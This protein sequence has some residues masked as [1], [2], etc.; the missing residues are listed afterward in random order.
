VSFL[1]QRFLAKI[2]V[3]GVALFAAG[4]LGDVLSSGSIGPVWPA[5]GIALGAVLLCGYSVWPAVAAGAFLIGFLPP[6]PLPVGASVIYAAGT[7]LAALAGAFFLLRVAKF[8]CSLLRLRD[9]IELIVLGAFASST[10]SASIGAAVLYTH[11]GSWSGFGSAWL[12]YWLGDS[13]GVLLVTPLMLTFPGLFSIRDW[14][15]TAEVAALLL[16]LTAGGLVVFG[17]LP[18]IPGPLHVL[19]FAV[20]PL[21]MWAA[22]RLGISVTALSIFAVGTIATVETAL[23]SGPFTTN[24][25]LMNA[26]LLDVFFGVVSVTGLVLAAAVA[27]REH[28]ESQRE[29]LARKQ[30]AM[31]LRLRLATIVESSDDAVIGTDVNGTV[32]DWNKGAERLFG[33]AASEVIGKNISFIDSEEGLSILKKIVNREAV[34]NYE[35]VRR[36]KDGTRVDVSLTVSPIFDATGQIV[37]VSKIARDVTERRQAEKALKKSEEKFSTAFRESP[38][39]LTLTSAK[40]HRYLDV[41]ETFERITGWH[42][43]DVIGRT[44]FDIGLWANPTDRVELI[45]LLLEKGSLRNFEV[46]ARCKDGT[47]IVALGSAELIQIGNEPCVLSV[48]ADITERKRVEQALKESESRFRRLADTAPV[49]IWMSG[50]DKLCTYF[51]KPWLDFTGRSIEE[52]LGNGWAAGIHADDAEGCLHIYTESFDRREDFSMEYRLR[53]YD[54]E[55]RWILDIGVPRYQEDGSFAGYIGSCVDITVRK[56]A[57]EA[58]SGMA[59]KLIE[60]Q[61]QERVR[62]ARELHDDINQRL[63]L[64]AIELEQVQQQAPDTVPELRTR[65]GVLHN[66]TEQ[67][68]GDVQ[69][70]SHELHSSKLENLGIVP[71]VRGFCKEFGERHKVEIDFRSHDVPRHLPGAVSVCLF[72]VTQEA[73]QNAVKYSGVRRFD[74]E[75]WASAE[76][77]H[78]SVSDSGKGFD[79]EATMIGTGLGLTSMQERVKL[80][81]GELSIKSQRN[82]GTTIHA[83]VPISSESKSRRAAG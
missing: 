30:A 78:L 4:K 15:R 57:E 29:Q 54:G 66:Q 10:V 17:D 63:A 45:K 24:T 41:N 69:K 74:V 22:I 43:D 7:T 80:V 55:Y 35:T 18:L 48:L 61:E 75:L 21:V 31:E 5:S 71:A 27:E 32:T 49:L 25:P 8:D 52:E 20:L 73:L 65:I 33:Y 59:G 11:L 36:R 14:K 9:V 82:H 3:V 47:L 13:T 28:A 81:N 2:V 37:G 70:M 76:E 83:C 38:M 50:T 1:S 64:L 40:D 77:I 44:P 58:L 23:G 60:A 39:V 68:S 51:N 26:V 46:N 42:R 79:T 62:I 56:Q 67:I 19:A 53:H 12:I 6:Q 34:K 72:R 16:F